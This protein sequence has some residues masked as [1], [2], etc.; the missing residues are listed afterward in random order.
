MLLRG[1]ADN[2]DGDGRP[3]GPLRLCLIKRQSVMIVKS[4]ARV[5]PC[6]DDTKTSAGRSWPLG[7]SEVT[8]P[9]PL[10]YYWHGWV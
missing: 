10:K 8:V 6:H 2:G 5:R 3:N 9:I 7:D 1:A 4:M